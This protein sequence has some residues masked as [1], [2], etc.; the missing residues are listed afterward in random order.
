MK[1]KPITTK[2]KQRR[3]WKYGIHPITGLK[4]PR[5]IGGQYGLRE[6]STFIT[7]KNGFNTKI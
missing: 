5:L 6:V 3:F 4:E 7:D 2:Q 1:N